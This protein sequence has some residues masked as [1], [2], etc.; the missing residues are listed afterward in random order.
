MQW[1][2]ST[3]LS[4]HVLHSFFFVSFFFLPL[5][6][7]R[8]FFRPNPFRQRQPHAALSSAQRELRGRGSAFW[9]KLSAGRRQGPSRPNCFCAISDE[10][11]VMGTEARAD[12]PERPGGQLEGGQSRLSRTIHH[13]RCTRWS[14]PGEQATFPGPI[15]YPRQSSRLAFS[16]LGL[17]DLHDNTWWLQGGPVIRLP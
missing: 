10:A 1:S 3:V 5:F 9:R 17:Y 13:L 14:D 6:L 15:E 4:T 7:L 16:D 8:L 2:V 11:S 12:V